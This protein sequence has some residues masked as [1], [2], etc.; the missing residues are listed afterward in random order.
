M[1]E[2]L[3]IQCSNGYIVSND[4][5]CLVYET[6]ESAFSKLLEIFE[7]RTIDGYR[8]GFGAVMITRGNYE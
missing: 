4:D 7:D 3:I 8:E 2:A 1:K 5:D 6:L